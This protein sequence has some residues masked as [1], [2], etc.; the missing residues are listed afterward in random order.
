MLLTLF[1]ETLADTAASGG[2]I[3]GIRADSVLQHHSLILLPCLNPDGV[4]I[5]IH[6]PTA[7]GDRSS[8]VQRMME[9]HPGA[10]WQANVRGV[11]L[12]HNFDAGWEVLREL[13]QR[14]GVCVPGPTRFGGPCPFSEPE[15]AAVRSLCGCH[16]FR[17]LFSFHAQGRKF[18][19]GMAARHTGAGTAYCPYSGGVQRLYRLRPYRYS[20]PWWDE[21]LVYPADR[22]SRFYHRGGQRPKSA[23]PP[24]AGIHLGTAAGADDALGAGVTP[25]EERLF[26]FGGKYAIL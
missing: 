24:A 11:D 19:G 20:R 2:S 4:E 17:Q 6:G 23:S 8:S 25:Q 15:T 16:N 12:N 9:E 1:A 22:P 26:P 13:E 7:A 14:S 18:T 10:V 5:A 3:A 21:G